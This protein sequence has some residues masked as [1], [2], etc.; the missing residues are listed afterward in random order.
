M[1]KHYPFGN[2]ILEIP[3]DH[4]ISVIHRDN[5]VYDR[6]WP[7]FL[8]FFNSADDPIYDIGANVGD[9]SAIIASHIENPIV[10][11]EGGNHYFQYLKSNARLLSNVVHLENNFVVN[12][13]SLNLSYVGSEG[14]GML[15]LNDEPRKDDSI[16]V[17]TPNE[18]IEKYG[19]PILVKI[20][21]DGF[22]C[23]II[24][25]FNSLGD[26]N[27]FFECDLEMTSL[28]GG[29]EWYDLISVM[30]DKGYNL[31]IFENNGYP[32]YC[33]GSFREVKRLLEFIETDLNRNSDSY[34]QYFDIL[35][36]RKSDS[37]IFSSISKYFLQHYDRFFVRN[38]DLI[39]ERESRAELYKFKDKVNVASG[40]VVIDLQSQIDELKKH[41]HNHICDFKRISEL[42][43]E[44]VK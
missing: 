4:K 39:H 11:V 33:G 18:L 16:N 2:Y 42:I 5:P 25:A 23:Q 31:L 29:G 20:D 13:S 21:T 26:F 36:I 37:S 8:R 3:E 30:I 22:D 35:A 15:Q 1:S 43:D 28:A 17:I 24:Q 10:A 14:S 34:I 38:L 6:F 40:E 27:Y 7:L 44:L 41:N 32:V 9:T 12:N 19:K